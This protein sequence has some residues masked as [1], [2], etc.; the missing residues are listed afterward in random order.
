VV[1]VAAF[2]TLGYRNLDTAIT[3]GSEGDSQPSISSNVRFWVLGFE[4]SKDLTLLH[5]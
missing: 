2:Q 5:R 1:W 3:V 4:E